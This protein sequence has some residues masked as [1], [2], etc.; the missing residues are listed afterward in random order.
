[1]KAN[2]DFDIE[3]PHGL[4]IVDERGEVVTMRASVINLLLSP[5]PNNENLSG[6]EK[7]ERYN[8]AVKIS[9]KGDIDL[10]SEDVVRIKQIAARIAPIAVYG[11]LMKLLAD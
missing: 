3:T 11:P 8:L 2:F 6:E 5:S 9:Q 10:K 7:M 4:K 1:M